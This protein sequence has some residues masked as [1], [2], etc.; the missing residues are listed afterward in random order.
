MAIETTYIYSVDHS[1]VL[2]WLQENAVP[3]YFD[4][5]EAD[6]TTTTTVNCYV[7]DTVLL[8]I[9]NA[10][11]SVYTIT[12][13]AGTSSTVNN[14]LTGGYV[15]YGYKTA[16]GLALAIGLETSGAYIGL[17]IT[18]DSAGNTAIIVG[19]S[20]IGNFSGS[21]KA[22]SAPD[23][24]S[25]PVSFTQATGAAATI[26]APFLCGCAEGECR[27][28]PDA[29]YMPVVQ[30]SGISGTIVIDGVRYLTNSVWALRDE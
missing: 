27:H 6:E 24:K 12:T 26:L 8:Q 1:G 7:G 23:V 19:T 3:R 28:T 11:K 29:F 4:R 13:A 10:T 17:F 18:K 2:A 9:S 25:L 14:T 22:I 20:A 30:Y 5:V 16:C 15:N 21:V